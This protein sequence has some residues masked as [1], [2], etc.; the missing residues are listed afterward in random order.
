MQTD[1]GEATHE[2]AVTKFASKLG[3]FPLSKHESPVRGFCSVCNTDRHEYTK[4][5]TEAF[6][7]YLGRYKGELREYCLSCLDKGCKENVELWR[8]IRKS[9]PWIG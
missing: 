4:S 3:I 6:L 5:R 1:A 2:L 7:G 9:T 8:H